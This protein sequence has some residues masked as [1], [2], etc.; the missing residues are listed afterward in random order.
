MTI[1]VKTHLY[2]RPLFQTWSCDSNVRPFWSVP[3]RHRAK[4]PKKTGWLVTSY[5]LMHR[6]CSRLS[7]QDLFVLVLCLFLYLSI[8]AAIHSSIHLS[9][10]HPF[11]FAVV[12]SEDKRPFW[13]IYTMKV[14]KVWVVFFFF[15]FNSKPN[16]AEIIHPTAVITFMPFLVASFYSNPL[17]YCLSE[18]NGS[19]HNDIV[20]PL[21]PPSLPFLC[22]PLVGGDLKFCFKTAT[23]PILLNPLPCSSPAP[24]LSLLSILPNPSELQS[25]LLK[26]RTTPGRQLH[27]QG[28]DGGEDRET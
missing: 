25:E 7:F 20:L 13:Y 5:G 3:P 9:N 4:N 16:A 10:P 22:S 27:C 21:S 12:L 28:R 6:V 11:L 15:L 17:V 14:N 19:K 18:D 26:T 1:K 2:R 23:A 24:P 8:H